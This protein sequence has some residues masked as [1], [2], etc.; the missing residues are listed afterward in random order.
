MCLFIHGLLGESSTCQVD[1]I[2]WSAVC[3]GVRYPRP[4]LAYHAVFSKFS[5]LYIEEKTVLSVVVSSFNIVGQGLTQCLL[6]FLFE[7]YLQ[8]YFCIEWLFF[9]CNV[10]KE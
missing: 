2:L 7:W 4:R 3:C 10:L 1:T 5:L 9:V 6:K 8:V